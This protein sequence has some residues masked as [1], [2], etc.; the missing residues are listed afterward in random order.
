MLRILK[1]LMAL[2]VAAF[3][4]FNAYVYGNIITYRAVAPHKSAFMSMRMS[5]FHEEGRSAMLDYRWVPYDR[6]S[7]N[8]KKALIASEDAKFAAH[9]GFDW[10]GIQNA[11]RHNQKSGEVKAGGSTISQ[12]LAKNLFLNDSRSYIRKAEEAAITAMMEAVT[13]KDRIFELYLNIIEWHYGVFGAEA[14]SQHFYKKPAVELTKQQ[15]AKLAARVPAP[16]FYADNPKSK[17]LRGKTNIILRRMGSAEL[18][19]TDTE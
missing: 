19:V 15:A 9:D 11:I 5:Q 14:A 16:L 6:I 18:P 2:P 12:Q 4:L 13:D 17:R 3:I 8:L 1:W 10:N 7:T